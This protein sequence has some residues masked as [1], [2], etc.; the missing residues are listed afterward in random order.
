MPSELRRQLMAGQ[1]LDVSPYLC[2]TEREHASKPSL[3]TVI[4]EDT[5]FMTNE[6]RAA[7]AALASEENEWRARR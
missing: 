5:S 2:E 7:T 3:N 4:Q 1:A 6:E